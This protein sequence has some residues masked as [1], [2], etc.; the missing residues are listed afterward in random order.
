MSSA[1][2]GVLLQTQ[3]QVHIHLQLQLR[4]DCSYYGHS[5]WELILVLPPL[6]LSPLFCRSFA[7]GRKV[8]VLANMKKKKLVGF[9]SEGM[10]L[11]AKEVGDTCTL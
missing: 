10:V 4:Y 2:L 5:N 8:L 7:Q 6:P 9:P 11:C 1:V 3:V